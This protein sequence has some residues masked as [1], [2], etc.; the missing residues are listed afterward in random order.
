VSFGGTGKATERERRTRHVGAIHESPSGG[1]NPWVAPTKNINKKGNGR[2][3]GA[4]LAS[5]LINMINMMKK[6]GTEGIT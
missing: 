5:A 2:F 4:S 6:P 3:V 1:G